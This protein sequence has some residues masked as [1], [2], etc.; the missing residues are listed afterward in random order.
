MNSLPITLD[1]LD[2]TMLGKSTNYD[3]PQY[4]RY[5]H[6]TLQ[7][8]FTLTWSVTINPVEKVCDIGLKKGAK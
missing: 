8:I 6:V 7:L 3:A 5:T 1:E 4:V 2:Q